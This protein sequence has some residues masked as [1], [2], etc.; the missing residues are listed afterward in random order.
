MELELQAVRSLLIVYA[1]NWT[2]VLCKRGT[3]P[4]L[5]DLKKLNL[6][7]HTY[8]YILVFEVVLDIITSFPFSLFSLP[9]FLCSSLPIL[10]QIYD[11]HFKTVV[12]HI[13]THTHTHTH[14]C[15]HI[16]IHMST[17]CLVCILLLVC[18]YVT[19]DFST[20]ALL[21]Q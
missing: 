16:A 18:I 5:Q 4:S 14:E 1:G 3:K 8:I 19:S 20:C 7:T 13:H 15:V 11:L 12:T 2:P 21:P 6:C 10:S 9:P 17:T